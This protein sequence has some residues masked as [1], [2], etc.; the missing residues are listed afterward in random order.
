MLKLDE[1]G[2]QNQLRHTE[3]KHHE[4]KVTNSSWNNEIMAKIRKITWS[5][6]YKLVAL[7]VIAHQNQYLFHWFENIAE[8]DDQ[9]EYLDVSLLFFEL[10]FVVLI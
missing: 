3:E 7:R 2:H 4:Q 1:S 9:E 10:H 8:E 5:R 6:I